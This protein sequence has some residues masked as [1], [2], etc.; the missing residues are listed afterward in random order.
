M[1]A[2]R[3]RDARGHRATR[4][5]TRS[6]CRCSAPTCA[7]RT[8]TSSSAS[9]TTARAQL[10]RV[11]AGRAP[12]GDHHRDLGLR[13]SSCSAW[14]SRSSCTGRSSAGAPCARS[15]L[16]PYGIITVVAA[17]SWQYAWSLD[18]RLDPQ[19][20]RASTTDPLS[21]TLGTYVAIIITEVWKTRRS[22]RCCCWP[23]S[24]S[25]PTSC[26]RRPRSTGRQRLAALLADHAAADEAGDPRRAAVPHARRVPDLRHDLHP[27]QRRQNDTETVSILGYNQLLNRL[28]LGLGS[29][30]SVLIFLMVVAL[31]AF[32][33]IKGFGDRPW[34]GEEGRRDAVARPARSRAWTAAH[35]R[36]GDRSPLDPRRCGSC[37]CR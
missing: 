1:R 5:S 22:W 19:A 28:N 29:A 20:A 33:F 27:H 12:H 35:H 34:P 25:C 8:R 6:S 3:D 16:I 2:G 17:Y 36:R 37:R 4:S 32:V 9:P 18:T 14:C 11:V 24:R 23:G 7:S 31:I 15:I 21:H 30:V 10:A 26:T 13:S